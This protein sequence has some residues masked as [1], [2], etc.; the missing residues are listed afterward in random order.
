M[1][2]ALYDPAC[3]DEPRPDVTSVHASHADFV[4][5]SLQRL[6][7]RDAD[8]EDMLQEVFVVVHKRLHTYRGVGSLTSWLF[9]ICV[10]VASNYRRWAWVRHERATAEGVD[11]AAESSSPDD[12]LAAREA[13]ATLHAILDRM[14]PDK[15][16]VFVMFELEELSCDEIASTLGIPVG[17]VHS[18]LHVARKAFAK[19]IA[20]VNA[21]GGRSQR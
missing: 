18:R 21:S 19:A 11:Q 6:G 16:A 13:R 12:D 20:R 1:V 14:A 8:L 7:V 10:R 2:D 9:G 5:R 4:W 15:R 17:T 3:A